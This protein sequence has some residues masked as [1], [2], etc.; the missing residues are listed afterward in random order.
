MQASA[1]VSASARSF[2][3]YCRVEKG[4]AAN[5]LASYRLDLQKLSTV[6]P[7]RNEEVTSEE[8]SRYVA[9]LFAEGMAARSV[10]RHVATLRNYYGFLTRE[11]EIATDPTEFLSSPR[12]WTTLPK[13]L[14]RA[15]VEGLLQAPPVDTP[16]GVRDRAMLELLY[17]T[18]MRVSE[19][20]ELELTGVERQMGVLR[21]TGKGN[22]QRM[23]PFGEPARIALE[24]YLA[25]GRPRLLKGRA[26]KYVFVTAR[27]SAMTR[28]GF[29]KL[30]KGYGKQVGIFRGLTPHVVRHSFAT[31]LV[32]GGADLRSVQVM[33]GHADISTTQVYTHVA[34]RRL[35][36]VLDQHHPRA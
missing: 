11:G 6:L 13:Y 22:K 8:L 28:Q 33:L 36:E 27:G 10:A 17:A 4:L 1:T 35:R 5:S 3:D 14:N 24:G 25:D 19:L 9:R 32:E 26:T 30:L 21:V 2:L 31:H 15:E 34:R 16:T 20:C 23:V 29:W 7:Q 12:Q 18:G